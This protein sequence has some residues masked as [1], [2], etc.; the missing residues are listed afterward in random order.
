MQC[1]EK[2]VIVPYDE[3]NI[4]KV[5]K[6]VENFYEYSAKKLLNNI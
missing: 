5:F 1:H 4:S 6:L 2:C 3:N